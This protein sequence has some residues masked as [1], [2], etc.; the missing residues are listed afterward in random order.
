MSVLSTGAQCGG[1]QGAQCLLADSMAT[2]GATVR[3][4]N[5]SVCG[6]GRRAGLN[7]QLRS[8]RIGALSRL[9]DFGFKVV[10]SVLAPVGISQQQ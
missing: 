10:V 9:P 5:H 2:L 7:I 3:K 4:K 8:P 1:E 6:L